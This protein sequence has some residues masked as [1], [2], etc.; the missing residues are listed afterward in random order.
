M[1]EIG[2]PPEVRLMASPFPGMD[3]YLE[4]Q[5]RWPGFHN[6][7]ITHSSEEL[8]R[9]LPASYV[10]QTDV[11]IALVSAVEVRETWIEIFHLPEMELV[12]VVEILSPSNKGGS[13]RSEYLAKRN[14]FIDQPV[15]LVEIDLLLSG[16]RMLMK[17][18]LP[19]GNYFAI[20]ARSEGRPDA[21]VY[22]WSVRDPLPVIPIRLRA[23]ESD[24]PLDLASVFRSTYDRG[25]YNRIMRYVTPV[26]TSLP[27]ALDD[28]R[29]AEQVNH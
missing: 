27:L 14:R 6:A 11:R 13:G 3:P 22:S 7:L 1:N 19:D 20:V 9:L 23:P 8:N 12:T 5:G 10:A 16:T 17:T 26:P 4:A 15:N 18:R 2:T 25:G 28:R 29:W 21:A 24:V